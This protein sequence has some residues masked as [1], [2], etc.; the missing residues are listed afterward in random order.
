MTVEEIRERVAA[1]KRCPS[2]PAQAASQLGLFRDVLLHIATR[3]RRRNGGPSAQ[4]LAEEAL[5]ALADS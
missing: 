3:N 2:G 5:N 1:V 4:V